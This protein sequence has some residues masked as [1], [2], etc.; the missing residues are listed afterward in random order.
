MAASAAVLLAAGCSSGSDDDDAGR[1]DEAPAAST[2]VPGGTAAADEP[3]GGGGSGRLSI[4]GDDGAVLMGSMCYFEE[5]PAAAGGGSILWTVQVQGVTSSDSDTEPLTIDVSR[6]SDE[7]DFAGD[8]V[9]LTIGT[10]GGP[11]TV[12]YDAIAP[13]GTVEVVEDESVAAEDL[14]LTGDDGSTEITVSF[15]LSC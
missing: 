2:T 1:D 8:S 5:Q 11:D 4:D 10:P 12:T 14:A 7:S 3:G 15:E 13:T 6:Y 9:S